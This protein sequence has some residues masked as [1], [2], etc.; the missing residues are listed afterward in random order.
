MDRDRNLLFGVL[1]VQ[2]RKVT[3]AQLVDAAGAWATDPSR[4]LG[5]RLVEA[6][7][8]TER[9][10]QLID[11][12][13]EDAVEAYGG[14]PA[15]TLV[16]LGGEEQVYE[17]FQGSVVRTAKGWESSVPPETFPR[18]EEDLDAEVRIHEIPGRYREKSEH[19]RG[20]MGRVL[21]VYDEALGR[22]IVLKELLPLPAGA[23]VEQPS[24]VRK[25]T[26]L[27]ARFLREART[28]GRLEH[29]SIVPV[30]ELGQRQDG[31][32]YYTMKLVRGRTLQDA[33][34]KAGPLR[35]RLELLSHFVDLCQALAYA[36]SRGVV[37][38][39][40]KPQNVMVGEFGETV[41]IDWGLAKVKGIRD[42]SDEE[43]EKTVLSSK[44]RTG[45]E[46][47]DTLAGDV[48]GTPA[49]M[50]PEQARGEIDR[51]DE[52]SDVYSLGVI[53]YVLLTGRLPFSEG[54]ISDVLAKVV[55]EAPPSARTLEPAA[56]AELAAICAR[57]MEK[58][59]A[60]RYQSA[61]ELAEDVERFQSGAL[62]HSYQYTTGYLVRRF[63]SRHKAIL[64]T[65]TAGVLVA[66]ALSV[67]YVVTLGIAN[68]D[69]R[70]SLH[71]A[72]MFLADSR[73]AGGQ[74]D[75]AMRAL[76]AV[77]PDLRNWE[78]G[79][80]QYRCRSR[81]WATLASRSGSGHS[82]SF[83]GDG[84][85]VVTTSWDQVAKIWDAESGKE[86]VTLAGHSGQVL[87]ASFSG[88][89]CRVVTASMD[90]TAK[91]WDAESGQEL[92]TLAGHSG[93]WTSASFTGD[94]CRVVTASADRTAKIW[95]A[96]SG[97]E[98]ATLAGDPKRISTPSLSWDGRRAF[99]VS[100]D[101]TAKIWDAE[102]GQELATLAG[103]S[104]N[105]LFASFS[106]DGR[107]VVTT[108][109]GDGTAKI[110][111]AESGQELATLAGH[112]GEWTSAS[113]SGD[114]RRVVT[115]SSD[116]TA[117]IWDA[118]SGKELAT[119]IGHSGQVSCASF[120]GD[121][122]RVLT[123]TYD[124]RTV[125]VWDAESGKELATLAGQS[126]QIFSASF[127]T[128]GRRVLTV[129]YDDGTA[130]IWVTESEQEFKA[131]AGPSAHAIS[132]AS[133]SGDGRRA[134][135]VCEDMPEKIWDAESGQELA[136]LAGHSGRVV[137]AS[138]SGDGR[139]VVTLDFSPTIA[140]IWDAESG[141]ELAALSGR[142]HSASM[143]RD[144][145][146]VLTT[147]L[148]SG[149][150]KILDA[151]SGKELATLASPVSEGFSAF[152]GDGRRVVTLDITGTF[153]TIWDAESGKVLARCAYQSSA[154]LYACSVWF[155]GDGQRVVTSFSDGTAKI[156]DAGSGKELATLAGHS[157]EVRSASF[158]GD[159]RRV[160]TV[161]R[162]RTAKIWDAESG[163]E[164]ATLTGHAG[165]MLAA[166][167]SGDGRRVLTI[168]A[169]GTLQTLTAMPWRTEDMPGD[170]T[171]TL[172]QRLE[173]WN[174]ERIKAAGE[175]A[176]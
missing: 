38:R 3:P 47:A 96:E 163:K 125:K 118:A 156:W 161:S 137:S 9:D 2:L 88:D 25:S 36:H 95:D 143:S 130:K 54:S 105:M 51:I 104:G 149:T 58:D 83:S 91:I 114:G 72:N 172:D 12:F 93:E 16:A 98:L 175:S 77:P 140:T 24:P 119:L 76:E 101:G 20:A 11:R 17:T 167:F 6:G 8:L 121:G 120:S 64:S 146:R 65:A 29:P 60:R 67:F 168:S 127:S 34:Q 145:R 4:D 173:L 59:P 135:I 46:G 136:T 44:L 90:G 18:A 147:T 113:F 155:S 28:T 10:R 62:V 75:V 142:M 151:E 84:G 31:T 126:G 116:G 115:G 19:G 110:W 42:V 1:G 71:Q 22:E 158:S 109:R 57:A 41:V 159:G 133:F 61:K 148:P 139:R 55:N 157:G 7:V 85:R 112:S 33:L 23:S 107:R 70:R 37:H 106:R 49:Y 102:S 94:G 154:R 103:H 14:N 165:G 43:L 15:A 122:R 56:P 50:S 21:L 170:D 162:D 166:S 52:R 92:A 63:V 80:M 81:V 27:V 86:L 79:W 123:V 99:N 134:L 117:K 82:V 66:V 138:F 30:Y 124:D 144:G 26:H 13:V 131:L 141:K 48:L 35:R 73:I 97:K 174:R 5:S 129:S 39:D 45:G 171:M 152:S 74:Y 108:A 68:D 32:L 128:D 78:W 160:L 176:K 150:V 100:S 87:S 132:Y 111:D 40:L 164:L 169:D 69:L 53:L 89:G 153:A